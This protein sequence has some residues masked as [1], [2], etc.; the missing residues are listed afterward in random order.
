MYDKELAKETIKK[1]FER[2]IFNIL[3][4]KRKNK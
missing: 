1:I 3:R 2:Y 4:R